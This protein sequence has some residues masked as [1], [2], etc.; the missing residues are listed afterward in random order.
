MPLPSTNSFEVAG[1]S[2]V[3]HDMSGNILDKPLQ[4]VWGRVKQGTQLANLDSAAGG[5]AVTPRG[6]ASGSNSRSADPHSVDREMHNRVLGIVKSRAT[7]ALGN[8]ERANTALTLYFDADDQYLA[9]GI[10]PIA[11]NARL[12]YLLDYFGDLKN[13]LVNID[14]IESV[15][16]ENYASDGGRQ[17]DMPLQVVWARLKRGAKLK[18]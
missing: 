7:Q 11:Q 15:G 5:D 1:F 12:L 13:V 6:M 4:I 17:L 14:D 16:I 18:N 8:W 3:F 9:H 10:G 2:T